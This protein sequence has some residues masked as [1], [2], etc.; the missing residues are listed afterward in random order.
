MLIECQNVILLNSASASKDGEAVPIPHMLCV[1][2]LVT[3]DLKNTL[4]R[5]RKLF[6]GYTP[7]L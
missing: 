3:H 7:I 6:G 1:F 4:G 5:M 2:D